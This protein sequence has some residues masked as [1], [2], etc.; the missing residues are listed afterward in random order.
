MKN[1]LL[2]TLVL[3]TSSI[4][5]AA[6]VQILTPTEVYSEIK[7]SDVTVLDVN[8]Q[9]IYK[10][11]HVPKA[12]NISFSNIENHLPKN[13]KSRIIFYC[14]SEMCSASHQAAE[15]AVKAGYTNVARMSAGIAGWIKQRLPTETIQ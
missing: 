6:N 11:G 7:K 12:K 15:I 14:M 10:K 5:L 9:F 4:G 8:P 1:V 2:L 3:F 13:K